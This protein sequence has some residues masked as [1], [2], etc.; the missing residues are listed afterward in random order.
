[1]SE[2]NGNLFLGGVPTEPD[3]KALMVAF[4]EIDPGA[5]VTY[6]QIESIINV[7]RGSSRF[8]TV[9]NAWRSRLLKDKNIEVRPLRGIGLRRL[10]EAERVSE[11]IGG[12]AKGARIIRRSGN[13]LMRVEP[14]RLDEIERRKRDHAIR[15][16]DAAV[17]TIRNGMREIAE[18]ALAP[19]ASLPRREA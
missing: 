15:L 17:G 19:V 3:V 7:K 11:N 10:T 6:E 4:P 12:V 13:R 18:S 1:M 8:V 5:V 9:T 14:A 16:A 2:T